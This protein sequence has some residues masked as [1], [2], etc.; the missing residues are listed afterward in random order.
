MTQLIPEEFAQLLTPASPSSPS[1][2]DYAEPE[3]Y[4]PRRLAA[5][6]PMDE[7]VMHL[8]RRFAVTQPAEPPPVLANRAAA[9]LGF[10][11]PASYA[12]LVYRSPSSPS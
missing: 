8:P 12:R 3:P 7:P 5:S 10:P 6:A 1:E 4:A 9:G 2:E 11:D